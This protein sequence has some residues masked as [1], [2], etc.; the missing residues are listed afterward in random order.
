MGILQTLKNITKSFILAQFWIVMLSTE[1][2]LP[3]K[4]VCSICEK[5][6]LIHILVLP[7]DINGV[8]VFSLKMGRRVQ[9]K[10]S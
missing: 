9:Y 8:V 6:E 5:S 2:N 4:S 7:S 10:T 1:E 3:R